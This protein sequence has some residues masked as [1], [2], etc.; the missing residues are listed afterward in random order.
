M[1][2]Q[3]LLPGMTA[4]PILYTCAKSGARDYCRQNHWILYL[5]TLE[6]SGFHDRPAYSHQDMLR[7]SQNFTMSSLFFVFKTNVNK[8]RPGH[9]LSCQFIL[10]KI[11][12]KRED[13]R[14][15]FWMLLYISKHFFVERL[16]LSSL[17]AMFLIPDQQP[18]IE[19]LNTA[20]DIEVFAVKYF[21]MIACEPVSTPPNVSLW[22]PIYL[23]AV[24]IHISI[25]IPIG[26]CIKANNNY[27]Q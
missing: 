22:P 9:L 18:C 4:L 6:W 27:Y 5:H 10:R 23:V 15:C 21:F 16:I 11:F 8:H 19:G 17:Q 25:P 13:N 26:C 1:P 3:G 24:C 7:L 2:V 12:I 20:S 14:L